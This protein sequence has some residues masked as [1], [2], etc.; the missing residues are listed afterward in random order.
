[1][2]ARVA[3]VVARV[4]RVA[5]VVALSDLVGA[6]VGTVASTELGAVVAV[7]LQAA[8]EAKVG[9]AGTALFVVAKVG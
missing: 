3:M 2:V 7:A 9:A 1:M 4:A 5:V 8:V 6:G